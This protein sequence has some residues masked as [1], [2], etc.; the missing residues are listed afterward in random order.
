MTACTI[1]DY[2]R[3]NLFSVMR[4]VETSGGAPVL[5]S[6]GADITKAERLILPGVGAFGDQATQLRIS[7]VAVRHVFDKVGQLIAGVDIFETAIAVDVIARVS[8]VD[9][10]GFVI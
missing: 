10:N 8:R 7:I 4:A 5:S 3:G 9:G 6:D 1:V 2:G